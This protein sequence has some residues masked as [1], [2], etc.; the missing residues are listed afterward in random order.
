LGDGGSG[1]DPQGNGQNLKSLLGSIL[2]IDVDRKDDGKAYAVPKD[3]PFVGR[4]D[5]QPEI[6]AYGLRNVWGMSFDRQTGLFWAADVGQ[7]LW[8]E[9]DLIV[10]GGNYGWNVR[11]GK[12]SFQPRGNQRRSEFIEPIW[13]YHHDLGRSITGGAV[14][15]GQRMPNLVGYYFYA[16]YVSGKVWGLLYDEA[17]KKVLANKRI[18]AAPNMPFMAIGED[19]PGELHFADSFGNLW[20]FTKPEKK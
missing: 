20:W 2:R 14:Y 16:D 18:E 4:T 1:G 17:Q 5:A 10:K 19:E 6:Y 11:E 12:F 9:I 3:N 7:N 13:N 15:R 8:E